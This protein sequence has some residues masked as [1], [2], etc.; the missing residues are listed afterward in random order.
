MNLPEALTSSEQNI[1]NNERLLSFLSGTALLGYGLYKRNAAAVASVLFSAALLD[2]AIRGHCAISQM[3]GRNTAGSTEH[4]QQRVE[5]NYSL[6]IAKDP[7]EI[8][9]HFSNPEELRKIISGGNIPEIPAERGSR[10]ITPSGSAS[11]AQSSRTSERA[12]GSIQITSHTSNHIEWQQSALIGSVDLQKAPGGRGTEVKVVLRSNEPLRLMQ[13]LAVYDARR[14][15]RRGL[16]QLKQKLESGDVPTIV[17]QPSGR[18]GG[19]DLQ[20]GMTVAELASLT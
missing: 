1:S 14:K 13:Q 17:G 6:T 12:V 3:I 15:L 2:R 16:R 18:A 4:T 8:E 11:T 7:Q 5:A 19:R 9:R 10:T 20:G